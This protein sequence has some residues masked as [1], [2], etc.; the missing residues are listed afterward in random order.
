MLALLASAAL[1]LPAYAESLPAPNEYVFDQ[2]ELMADQLVWGVAHGVSLLGR[3]CAQSG[4]LGAADAWIRWQEREAGPIQ[5]MHERLAQYYF[6]RSEV[7]PGSVA[8]A[9]GLKT[10]LDLTPEQLD[11]ACATLAEALQHPRYDLA[12][13]RAELLKP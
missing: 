10:R 13:R 11:A 4:Q 8:N 5:A 3:R 9:L 12:G 1:A 7:E 2:P 6:Q